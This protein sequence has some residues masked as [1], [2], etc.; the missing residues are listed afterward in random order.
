VIWTGL[1]AGTLETVVSPGSQA[2]VLGS[3]LTRPIRVGGLAATTLYFN[4]GYA[5]I[6]VPDDVKLGIAD[7]ASGIP[8]LV[9]RSA[10]GIVSVRDGQV[11]VTGV[12]PA[13]PVWVEVGGLELGVVP[14]RPVGA[15]VFQLEFVTFPARRGSIVVRQGGRASQRG[16]FV[17]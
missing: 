1:N 9:E 12:D 13:L 5:V 6:Q 16:V 11:F 17:M 4:P 10:P 7:L 2:L 3:G 15:G 8:L 14:I